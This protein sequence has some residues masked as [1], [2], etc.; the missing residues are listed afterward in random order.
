V[1]GPTCQ[2][3]SLAL[4]MQRHNNLGVTVPLID[5]GIGRQEIK[6]SITLNIPNKHTLTFR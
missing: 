4:I 6:I 1:K 2:G 3:D 5:G